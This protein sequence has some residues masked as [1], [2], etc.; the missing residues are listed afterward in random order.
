MDMAKR[1][2]NKLEDA[3]QVER[4]QAGGIKKFFGALHSGDRALP[5]ILPRANLSNKYIEDSAVRF[6]RQLMGEHV[7]D[8]TNPKN[9]NNLAGRSATEVERLKGVDYKLEPW[10]QVAP[11]SIY[12]PKAGE[13]RIAIPGDQTVSN[14]TLVELNG[15]PMHSQQQGG[16]RYGLGQMHDPDPDKWEAWKSGQTQA[17]NLQAKIDRLA[18]QYGTNDVI[19][20]HFA[21]GPVANNYA[22]HM[23]DANLQAIDW[24]K[25][26]FNE[27]KKFEKLIAYGDKSPKGGRYPDWAGLT[28]Y[29]AAMDLMRTNSHARKWFNNRMKTPSDTSPAGLPNGL[30]VQW[31]VTEPRLRNMEI[32]TTGLMNYQM[33]PYRAVDKLGFNHNT[34]TD[35]LYGKAKGAQE[36]L[37][38]F[39]I[40]FPDAAQHVASTQLPSH[41]T[42]TIG[43]IYPHQVIDDQYINQYMQFIDRVKGLTKKDGGA[44]NAPAASMDGE[45]FFEAAIK[46][47]MSTDIGSL[48]KIVDLVNKG[49]S[50]D[51]AIEALTNPM[52]KRDGGQ[53][54]HMQAGGIKKAIGALG[55]L[56]TATRTP[57]V[58]EIAHQVAQRNAAKPVE[59]GGLG[60]HADNTA[61]DRAKALGFEH[62][63]YHGTDSPDIQAF[64]PSKTKMWNAIFSSTD[65]K[66][67]SDYSRLAVSKE[68]AKEMGHESSPN[69]MPLML[70]NTD[71]ATPEYLN[72]A[73]IESARRKGKAGLTHDSWAITIDPATIRSRF[74]AFDPAELSSPEILKAEGGRVEHMQ[75]GGV[76]KAF[77]VLTQLEKDFNLQRFL[78]DAAFKDRLYHGTTSNV[79][80]FDPNRARA[81]TGNLNAVLGTFMSD[82]PSE[83]SRFASEWGTTGG[84]VMPLYT[85]IKNPYSAS[86][87][88]M[89]DIAMG[90][91]RRMM[92][93]PSY[94]PNRSVRGFDK[95]GHQRTFD[96]IN[97]HEPGALQDAYDFKKELVDAGHDGLVWTLNGNKEVIAFDP[98][99]IKS[100]I[101]N[102]GTYDIN[103]GDITKAEGGAVHMQAGG[104][105]PRAG[106]YYPT[107]NDERNQAAGLPAD[108]YR[109]GQYD[110]ASHGYHAGVDVPVGD[111]RLTADLMGYRY[112]SPEVTKDMLA[113]ARLG[114]EFP[115]GEGRLRGEVTRP[116][117]QGAPMNFGLHYSRPFAEGGSVEHMQAGGVKKAFSALTQLEKDYN[118]TKFLEQSAVKDRL[119]HGTGRDITSFR[120][121]LESGAT[122]LTPNRAFAN[123]FAMDDLLYDSNSTY[124]GAPSGA[125]VMPVYAQVKNPWDYENP[126]HIEAVA[127]ILDPQDRKAFRK[128]A[129]TGNWLAIE[130][131]YP[132]IQQAGFD[133]AHVMEGDVKNLGV[134]NQ[135]AIKSALGNRGTYDVTDPDITK[136]D[137]GKVEH[138]Q[139]GGLKTLMGEVLN[140]GGSY[141]AR[142]LQ[143]AADEIPN[144]E[145]LYEEQA[146][147]RAFTGDNAKAVMTM[148]PSEFENYAAPLL[149]NLSK[150]SKTNID[151][152]KTIQGSGGFSDVPFLM[153][154]KEKQGSLDLPWITAH[155]GRHRSRAMDAA[156]EQ[157]G[158]VQ[159]LPRAELR[160]P[161]P[162]RSQDEYIAA[163][164]KEMELTGNKVKP[165]RYYV[166][167]TDKNTFQRPT[168][169]LPDIYAE[170]GAVHSQAEDGDIMRSL[171]DHALDNGD[172]HEMNHAMLVKQHEAEY[173]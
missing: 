14:Q 103:E 123:K 120:P 34:Y 157:A 41:F 27:L 28:D 93:D 69:V 156:G 79:T 74:A 68:R 48:N 46:A 119:Y 77:G 159:L 129:P 70:R 105:M 88:E 108:F 58:Y 106:I 91:Y 142:R 44:V 3:Y 112:V 32:N 117:Q 115:V 134:F 131:H 64:D 122:F 99:Q 33:Q 89:D 29:D 154:N 83:A 66:Q 62:Q 86:Y 38:P 170:G 152:L 7:T 95:E 82:N 60:L 63:T 171:L 23:A 124:R 9:L 5:L 138:M 153:I 50:I 92:Q 11:E 40:A 78:K 127:K 110:V 52:R 59:L 47:G 145:K 71:Y 90:V 135:K 151:K 168:I 126:K 148:R 111:A 136:A 43:K 172:I 72:P 101:G 169:D 4:M 56:T 65:P 146:I 39:E 140:R 102:R 109:K 97:K 144:L 162:R 37:T 80:E 128:Q 53:V 6:A 147:L 18:G 25:V 31:A 30:D 13:V 165:E 132:S 36:V 85:S 16:S 125:N 155:E 161:F 137:G 2:K 96:M 75:A 20:S 49:L 133:A 67:A 10:G 19:G 51:E 164:R 118:L 121:N 26:N 22:M 139:A 55:K 100:A 167:E 94:D 87:K 21:M 45:Q 166:R 116:F 113:A 8:S 158:L 130:D 17:K 35:T 15:M 143:R 141:A 76:K 84:N 73:S 173:G 57:T 98:K 81:K 104:I 114:I 160:E 163:L 107:S 150:D 61:M 54:E 1:K 42:G 12:T 149:S 24:S